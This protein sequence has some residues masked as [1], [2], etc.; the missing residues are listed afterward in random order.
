M[1]RQC[2]KNEVIPRRTLQDFQ[3][4]VHWTLI[5]DQKMDLMWVFFPHMVV[6]KFDEELQ[7][8]QK[9]H[10][11]DKSFFFRDACPIV[12]AQ[13]LHAVPKPIRDMTARQ[14]EG[15]RTLHTSGIKGEQQRH[16]PRVRRCPDMHTARPSSCIEFGASLVPPELQSGLIGVPNSIGMH[17]KIK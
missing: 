16:A 11:S 17:P 3:R 10:F 9:S 2:I 7:P 4:A 12:L 14:D 6:Q 5:Q 15:R 13:L 1:G 8:G